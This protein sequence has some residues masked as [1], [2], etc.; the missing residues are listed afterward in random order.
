M[1]TPADTLPNP[2]RAQSPAQ[3]REM[4]QRFLVHAEHELAAKHRLQA[5]EK[6]WGAIAHQYAAIAEQRGWYHEQHERFKD[7]ARYLDKEQE[8]TDLLLTLRGFESFHRNFYRNDMPSGDI[9]QGIAQ[10]RAYVEELEAL[11]RSGPRPY[12]VESEHDQRTIENLTRIKPAMLETSERGFNNPRHLRRRRVQWGKGPTDTDHL[13]NGGTGS[14][15]KGPKGGGAAPVMRPVPQPQQHT[16]GVVPTPAR[17]AGQINPLTDIDTGA[18]TFL[19]APR[20]P[21]ADALLGIQAG[22]APPA[23]RPQASAPP[24]SQRPR[25]HQVR[26]SAYRGLPSGR[27]ERRR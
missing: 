21:K 12:T 13:T 10:A 11:R 14:R 25:R 2:H 5:S 16:T 15:R 17:P 26:G 20:P 6:I 9:R 3:H 27:R 8:R 19:D 22:S 18:T 24:A 7:M 1:T 23:A 4:S